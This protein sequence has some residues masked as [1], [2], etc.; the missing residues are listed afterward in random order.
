MSAH[1]DVDILST[2]LDRELD[3]AVAP[4]RAAPFVV[5]HDA[6]QYFE[7][8]YDLNSAGFVS[9]SEEMVSR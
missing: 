8:A 9:S 2:Y 1:P 5:F 4:V 3:R 6:Y 7:K